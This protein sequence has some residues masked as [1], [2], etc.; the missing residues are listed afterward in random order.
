M[1]LC[2]KIILQQSF[3]SYFLLTKFGG[4]SY[5]CYIKY[6]GHLSF[7]RFFAFQRRYFFAKK[8][9]ILNVNFESQVSSVCG[10][11]RRTQEIDKEQTRNL[12]GEHDG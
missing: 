3:F 12:G 7:L 2:H 6:S 1:N 8:S 11:C 9:K 4:G 5:N 10:L